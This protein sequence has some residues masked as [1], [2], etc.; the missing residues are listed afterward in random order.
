VN[1]Y[2]M[3]PTGRSP[4]SWA[5]QRRTA[6]VENVTRWLA[7]SSPRPSGANAVAPGFFVGEQNRRLLVDERDELTA[8]AARSS[9]YALRAVR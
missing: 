6:A 1:V 8:G 7:W 3:P 4:G 5:T 9:T 2:S